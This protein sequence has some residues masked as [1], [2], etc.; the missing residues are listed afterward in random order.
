MVVNLVHSE[1]FFE[2]RGNTE[3][4]LIVPI[5]GQVVSGEASEISLV[6]TEAHTLFDWTSVPHHSWLRVDHSFSSP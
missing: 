2:T 4:I 3:K 1:L 6:Q 5:T